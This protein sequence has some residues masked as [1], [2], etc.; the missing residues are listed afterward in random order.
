MNDQ[1]PPTNPLAKSLQLLW[2]GLPDPEKGP[3]PKLT[4]E[5]IVAAGVDLADAEGID[6]LSMRKLAQ[7]LGVGTMS[8]YRYVPSKKELMNLMLDAVVGPSSARS[9]APASGWRAFL[10]RTAYEGRELYLNHPWT[11]QVNWSRPVLGPNSV[12]D[13]ELFMSGLNDLPLSDKHKMGLATT[14]DSYVMGTVRQELLWQ[15]A[16]SDSGMTD[17]E[18]WSYQVPTLTH[19][20]ASGRFP[21]M[22]SLSEDTFGA[23]WEETFDFGLQ[24]ILDGLEQQLSHSPLEDNG[25]A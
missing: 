22:A 19:A 12:A 21:V 20:F 15:N 4:L 3:K 7:K 16:A 25:G 14:L 24:L 23:T 11:L 6:A 18:F 5:Q 1:N 2:E 10:A 8:L 9:A 13:L 17:E